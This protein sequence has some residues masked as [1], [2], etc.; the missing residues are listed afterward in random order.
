M[1]NA[2]WICFDCR[3]SVR[4]PTHW[5]ANVPC[6]KC[7]QVCQCIGTKIPVPPKRDAKAWRELRESLDV[8]AI[9]LAEAEY[10]R[11][12]RQRHSLEQQI[13]RLESRPKN[14]GRVKAA[15]LLKR[16]L[17]GG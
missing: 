1:G 7:A 9:Q 14:D 8:Q 5:K 6:P 17:G 15:S 12:I 13:K 10:R 11:G 3:E 16:R 2:A 4:R